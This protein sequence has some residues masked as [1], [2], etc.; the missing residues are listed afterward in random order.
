MKKLKRIALSLI[1]I[2]PFFIKKRLF[3]IY[4]FFHYPSLR[5]RRVSF[6]SLN[7]DRIFYVIRPYENSNEGLMSLLL[8]VCRH[9]F[10]CEKKNYI[11]VVDFKNYKTQYSHNGN[12]VW[13]DYFE[14]ISP[15]SLEEV[16]SSKNVILC[17]LSPTREN[18]FEP[19]N[20]FTEKEVEIARRIISKYVRPNKQVLNLVEKEQKLFNFEKT[21]GLYLRGTD[22]LA[23]KPKGHYKQPTP[24]QTFDRVDE[25]LT[26]KDLNCIFL[27]T[28]DKTIFESVQKKY[29]G[30]IRTTTFDSF[31]DNYDGKSLLCDFNKNNSDP[32]SIYKN[33][34]YYLTKI[35]L[36]SRCS[37]IIGGNTC[38]SWASIIFSNTK[39][40]YFYNLGKY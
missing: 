39:N 7:N 18:L 27:V 15:Y 13:E 4:D 16:Y 38:G 14:P 29:K 36:L 9:I 24:E 12:N 40:W 31:I 10:Y 6:G 19:S 34:L 32:D 5:K 8:N 1:N 23:T 2:L 37:Y 17:G 30:T 21:L 33:G 11:P 28:E 25:V 3:N 26:L 35:L 20:R 22:Y